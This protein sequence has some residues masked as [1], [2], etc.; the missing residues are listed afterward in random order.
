VRLP[1]IVLLPLASGLLFYACDQWAARGG[2]A[3]WLWS[4]R[5][6]VTEALAAITFL[7]GAYAVVIWL[8]EA[9]IATWYPFGAD[10][11]NPAQWIV[12]IL[13]AWAGA[14]TAYPAH[15]W[16]IHRGLVHWGPNI[17]HDDLQG[18]AD[19]TIQ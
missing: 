4:R 12:L 3:R 18:T 7:I 15:L 13:A 5:P 6:L 1:L 8:G 11:S 9:W 2:R 10:L 19:E 17:H 14:V 16:L